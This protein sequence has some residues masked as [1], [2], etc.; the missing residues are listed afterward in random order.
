MAY[1]CRW[2]LA[3]LAAVASVAL[4]PA[5]ST[6]STSVSRRNLGAWTAGALLSVPARAVAALPSADRVPLFVITT[7]DGSTPLFT[8]AD[9]TR[10]SFFAERRDAE[11]KLKSLKGAGDAT[12][13]SLPLSEALDLK[14]QPAS[15]LGGE[16]LFS[17]RKGERDDA[18]AIAGAQA[19]PDDLP[20]FFDPRLAAPSGEVYLFLK[21]GDVD[22]SW[23]K[24]VGGKPSAKTGYPAYQTTSVRALEGKQGGPK[25]I[26]VSSEKF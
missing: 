20:L 8:D 2:T 3:A 4:R 21:K 7:A 11:A 23:A 5:P 16:F 24:A 14:K 26:I 18:S 25:F 9:G 15:E 12:V 13:M 10:A 22:K 19:D 6:K 1:T 17:A